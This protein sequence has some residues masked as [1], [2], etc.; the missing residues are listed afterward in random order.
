[1]I[2]LSEFQADGGAAGAGGPDGASD[3]ASAATERLR[4]G[5]LGLAAGS[6]A[7]DESPGLEGTAP[8]DTVGPPPGEVSDQPPRAT[9]SAAN[10]SRFGRPQ[11]WAIGIGAVLLAL[12]AAYIIDLLVTSGEIEHGISIAGVDVGGLTP[13]EATAALN[14]QVVPRYGRPVTVDVHG[15]S[16]SLDPAAAG[17]TPDVAGSIAAAGERSANPITRLTSFFRSTDLPLA[18]GID[19][20]TLTPSLSVIAQ[21]TALPPVEGSVTVEGTTVRSVAPVTGRDLQVP[22][23]VTAVADAWRA[24]DLVR[25]SVWCCPCPAARCGHRPPTSTPPLPN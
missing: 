18:V 6:S 15:E 20:P 19:Q 16:I 3:P 24:G 4:V 13:D 2:Q 7:A 12:T 5:A 11:S 21:Q 8:G 25:S 14:A 17:L 10:R 22:E 1:M 9:E 23:A